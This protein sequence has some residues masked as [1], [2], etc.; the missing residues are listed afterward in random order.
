M[1]INNFYR[2][3]GTEVAQNEKKEIKYLDPL[4]LNLA[5]LSAVEDEEPPRQAAAEPFSQ[6]RDVRKKIDHNY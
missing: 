4:A 5:I 3:S 6:K 1:N 2:F